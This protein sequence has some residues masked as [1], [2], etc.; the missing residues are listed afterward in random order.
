[1]LQEFQNAMVTLYV[2]ACHALAMLGIA[3][4]YLYFWSPMELCRISVKGWFR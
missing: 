4:I 3:S 2:A 1:M